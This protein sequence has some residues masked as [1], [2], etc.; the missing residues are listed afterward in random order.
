MRRVRAAL[1][2]VMRLI[3]RRPDDREFADELEAHLEMHI[4]DNIRAGMPPDEARRHA[5]L[6][7]GGVEVAKEA[8]R[9]RS[10]VP[11]V[12]H[13]IQDVRFAG[14]MMRRSPGFTLVV[15]VTMA[16]GIGA[17]SAM[18]SVVNGVLLRQL[19]F[20]DADRLI[21]VA[22]QHQTLGQRFVTW[23][24]Y[25]E[26][27]DQ[28]TQLDGLAAAWGQAFNLSGGGEP[29][30]L[31]G[32][33]ATKNYFAVLGVAAQVGRAFTAAD[34]RY[35][36]VISDQLWRRRFGADPDVIGRSIDLTGVPHVVIG[37]MPPLSLIGL[38]S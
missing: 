20:P 35:T 12:E 29:E 26:W 5:L 19:P 2:R 9:D 3:A 23:P 37:V 24:D 4:E 21:S 32:S 38:P 7:L 15:V 17:N 34:D 1:L 31:N 36:V 14:R 30:R 22:M 6:D 11:F 13:L 27:R 25:L 18:F 8:H 16:L 10:S 28:A 33:A